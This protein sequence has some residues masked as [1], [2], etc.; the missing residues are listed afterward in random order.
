MPPII[1]PKSGSSFDVYIDANPADTIPIKYATLADVRATIR[2]LER[3]YKAKKFPHTRISQVANIMTV[4]L[5]AFGES[6]K[7]QHDLSHRYFN[8]LKE[9][10][11]LP[12]DARY[13][14]SFRI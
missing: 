11:K 12:E 2:K 3:L 7:E 10:T 13:K 5:H 14:F 9:R 1:D 6:K 4:R 8:F